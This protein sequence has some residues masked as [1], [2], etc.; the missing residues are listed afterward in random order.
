M[1]CPACR[2][3]VHTRFASPGLVGPIVEGGLD[4]AADPGWAESGARSPAE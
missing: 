2:F 4:P 1:S 3:A